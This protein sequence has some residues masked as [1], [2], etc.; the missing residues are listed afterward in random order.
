MDGYD[1]V[2]VFLS[3]GDGN[4]FLPPPALSVAAAA[5]EH[6]LGNRHLRRKRGDLLTKR[7]LR[8][9]RGDRSRHNCVTGLPRG[10]LTTNYFIL[11]EI[12][13]LDMRML[14]ELKV[15]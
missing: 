9:I 6:V 1:N 10:V 4:A 5:E 7:G 12:Q 3:P 2:M 11:C 15:L 13:V 8:A 14:F